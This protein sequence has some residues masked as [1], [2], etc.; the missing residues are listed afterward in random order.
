MPIAT[1]S[2]QRRPLGGDPIHDEGR[3]ARLKSG[4]LPKSYFPEDTNGDRLVWQG[5]V[6]AQV[7]GGVS[8]SSMTGSQVYYVPWS[9]SAAYGTGSDTA[10][11]IL[12]EFHDETV[13]DW[14]VAPVFHGT[15]YEKRCYCGGGSLGSI[16]ASVKTDLTRITWR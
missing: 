6:V 9:A 8:E 15:A 14:L 3:P 12:R 7:T 5:L 2:F 13:T 11:G 16:P 10:V 4:F 1:Q